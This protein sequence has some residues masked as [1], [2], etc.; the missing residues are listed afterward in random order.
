V[1]LGLEV[2]LLPPLAALEE[3]KYHRAPRRRRIVR[4]MICGKLNV[5]ASVA[6]EDIV[7]WGGDR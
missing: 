1:L 3:E 5:G 7:V 4:T 6:C 2:E